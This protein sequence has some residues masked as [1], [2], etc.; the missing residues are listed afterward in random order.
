MFY[1]RDSNI[2][3]SGNLINYFKLITSSNLTRVFYLII[4]SSLISHYKRSIVVFFNVIMV[5][6]WV[7]VSLRPLT[8]A[9]ASFTISTILLCVVTL[10]SCYS[11]A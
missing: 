7:R 11:L 10:R 8:V 1:S 5:F 9:V 6:F 3:E 2:R 4:L